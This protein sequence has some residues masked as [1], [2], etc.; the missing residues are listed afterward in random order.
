ML[1]GTVTQSGS[2]VQVNVR[3]IESNGGSLLFAESVRFSKKEDLFGQVD[4]LA[5]RV[6]ERL[7]ESLAS[8][9]PSRSR[10]RLA[11]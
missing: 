7:G 9:S 3:A 10:T 1:A 6:R 8:D 4:Q 2:T 11:S 5:R